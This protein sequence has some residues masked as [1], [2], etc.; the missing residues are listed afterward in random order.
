MTPA[1]PGALLLRIDL[2]EE[3]ATRGLARRL[4]VLVRAGDVIALWGDLGA[5]KTVFARAFV[6]ALAPP[7]GDAAAARDEE[8]P[9]PTFTLVQVYERDPAPVWH[10]DLYRIEDRSETRELGLDEAFAEGIS[11]IEWPDRLGAWL[12]AG[13]LDLVLAFAERPE[14]RLAELRGGAGWRARLSE[15]GI[16]AAAGAQ[17][18]AHV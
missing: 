7:D 14:A 3:A 10:V 13:R 15:A 8:V 4:A 9:S 12:P 2:P 16:G 6:N 11:L 1:Q 18:P 17:A 5:G